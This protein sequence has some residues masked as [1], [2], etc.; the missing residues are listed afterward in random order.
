MLNLLRKIFYFFSPYVNAFERRVDR[1]FRNIKSTSGVLVVNADLLKLMQEDLVGVSVWAERKYKGYKYLKKSVRR[2]LYANRNLIVQKF[3]EFCSAHVPDERDE[4][5]R[6]LR[7]IAAFLRPGGVYEYLDT[8]SFGKLLVN[9][10]EGKMIGDCNQIVTFYIY[11]YSLKFSIQDLHIKILPEHVCL[12]FQSI[13]VECTSGDF[14]KYENGEVLPVTEIVSTNLL[15]MSDFRERMGKISERDMVKAAQL[16]YAISSMK[17]VVEKNLQVAY[18]NLAVAC[19]QEDDFAG[20]MFY[21]DKKGDEEMR[22]AI[23]AKKY[24][25]SVRRVAHVKT[26]EEARKYRQVYRDML[27][28]ARKMGD[29]D[30]ERGAWE[31]LEKLG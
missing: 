31:V 28:L 1:F 2:K 22:Q 13:D 7:Q 6:Y 5:L 9:P 18:H 8:A 27:D 4:R 10:D 23:Y 11:L 16:A 30:R 14:L 29:R 17:E 21:A 26:I 24:N 3:E 25:A 19:L 20:A 15:D 12:H